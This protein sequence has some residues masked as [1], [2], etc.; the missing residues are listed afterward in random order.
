MEIPTGLVLAPTRELCR[1]IYSEALKFSYR[2]A[3]KP[4]LLHGGVGNYRVQL[5]A[6]QRGCNLMIATPGRLNDILSQRLL[7]LNM[8]Q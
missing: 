7:E 3:V 8:C 1:Q 6:L 4:C 5:D 2:T